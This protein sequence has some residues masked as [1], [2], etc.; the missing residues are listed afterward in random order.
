[1]PAILRRIFLPILVL[2]AVTGALAFVMARTRVTS[3]QIEATPTAAQS[4]IEAQGRILRNEG[5]HRNLSLQ[6]EAFNLGRRLGKRFSP[7]NREQSVLVGTLT[8]GSER[9]NVQIMRKQTDDGE[10]IEIAIPGSHGPLTWDATQGA[11][12]GDEGGGSDRDLIE[13]LALDSPDQF[14]LAQ[15]RGASYYTIARNVRPEGADDGYAGPLWNIVRVD[16]SSR[17]EQKRP[18]SPWRLYYINT[19]TGLIDR[20]VSEMGGVRFEAA[21]SGWTEVGGEK[22]PGEVTWT[23]QGQTIMQFRLVNFSHAQL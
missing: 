8:L 6:P 18:R 5:A 9:R 1:M 2:L 23:S 4:S 7:G 19:S 20:I 10:R 3:G 22:V 14:V 12:S 15:L 16:D 17:D 11:L 13:R 21:L